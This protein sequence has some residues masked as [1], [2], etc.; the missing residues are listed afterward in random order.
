[1]QG[2]CEPLIEQ[3]LGLLNTIEAVNLRVIENINSV[4]RSFIA[5]RTSLLG[6]SLSEVLAYN[7][8]E[9]PPSALERSTN[10]AVATQFL[11]DLEAKWGDGGRRFNIFGRRRRWR[12]N[13]FRP[14][15]PTEFEVF[16]TDAQNQGV[17]SAC[18]AFA[19]TAAFET[20]TH[21]V[22]KNP[23]LEGNKAPRGLSQQNL[24]DC[25][26]NTHGLAGCD[27]G[28][29]FRYMQW[30]TGGGLSEARSWPYVDGGKKSE[31]AENAS[32]SDSYT[33]RPGTGRC[34]YRQEKPSVVLA[35]MLASW[36][37]HTERDLENILL[38]GHAIVTT[39]EVN[40]HFQF[41]KTGVFLSEL[42]QNWKL[43]PYRDY[44]WDRLRPLRHAVT[45][46]GFGVDNDTGLKFWKVKNSWGPLWGESG[47]FRIRK[48]YNRGHCGIGAY[49]AVA[50]C[51]TCSKLS[52]CREPKMPNLSPP[53][54]LPQEEVFLGQT[55]FLATPIAAQGAL[56]S[57]SLAN[58]NESQC[59]AT[60]SCKVRCGGRCQEERGDL[61]EVQCCAPLGG[62]GQR[63]YCP[64][65]GN[66]CF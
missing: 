46:V 56:T 14:P 22:G 48:G 9:V 27:G 43:G 20:C 55:T 58:I 11:D 28:K 51:R 21:R 16:S 44:Q 65:R 8:G 54:N 62:R 45:I 30:L 33:R 10:R 60:R 59:P 66:S 42:C 3:H 29:S 2:V 40:Q 26:F 39:M 41:Y 31:V 6:R 37:D 61:T 47:F 32:L 49:F 17:C 7:M 38:A 63:V 23:G 1:M 4:S 18:S 24:L 36:H 25:A 12:R 5:G 15:R 64:R 57:D 34:F 50:R 53:A 35:N 52:R 19:V 13:T